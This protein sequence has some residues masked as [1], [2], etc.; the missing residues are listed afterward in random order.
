MLQ[1]TTD[2]EKGRH[3]AEGRS[4]LNRVAA[5]GLFNNSFSSETGKKSE[6]DGKMS[7]GRAS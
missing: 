1:R 6:V 2:Q 3:S 7:G 5:E 4:C